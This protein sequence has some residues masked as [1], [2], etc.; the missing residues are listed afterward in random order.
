MDTFWEFTSVRV[1]IQE[2]VDSLV[3]DDEFNAENDRRLAARFCLHAA[4]SALAG[5]PTGRIE[6]H[7]SGALRALKRAQDMEAESTRAARKVTRR[8]FA[9]VSAAS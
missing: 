4:W 3:I 5:D 8:L 2:V 9:P 1:A 7:F 6:K